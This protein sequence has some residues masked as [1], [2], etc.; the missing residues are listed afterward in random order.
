MTVIEEKY[1]SSY[2]VTVKKIENN[3]K[4][5]VD[6]LDLS[7]ELSLVQGMNLSQERTAQ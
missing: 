2:R 5:K 7:G 1:V 3:K 4:L 6:P